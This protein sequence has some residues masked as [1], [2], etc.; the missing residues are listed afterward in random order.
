MTAKCS[1]SPPGLVLVHLIM[2]KSSRANSS[3]GPLM[4]STRSALPVGEESEP[5]LDL[6]RGSCRRRR[7][8]PILRAVYTCSKSPIAVPRREGRM[9]VVRDLHPALADRSNSG[10]LLIYRPRL[11]QGRETADRR[12]ATRERRSGNEGLITLGLC[13]AA[14]H[15]RARK[16]VTVRIGRCETI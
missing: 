6:R 15:A 3:S 16:G 11:R 5:P 9:R 2:A 12:S 4:I 8:S 1:S 7:R 13:I 10:V 14:G